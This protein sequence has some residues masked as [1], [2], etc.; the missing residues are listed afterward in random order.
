MNRAADLLASATTRKVAGD[1]GRD[2]RDAERAKRKATQY[3]GLAKSLT[4]QFPQVVKTCP[5]APA[6]CATVDRQGTIDALRGLYANQRN[7]VMRIVART[8]WRQTNGTKRDDGLV[9]QAKTLEQQGLT[10]LGKLPRFETQ[11]K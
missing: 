5:E 2:R 6:F 4:I 9:K 10:E 1:R 3:E 7:S 8:F 11:C